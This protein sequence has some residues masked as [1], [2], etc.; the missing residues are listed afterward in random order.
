VA[1]PVLEEHP[2]RR[3][4][5]GD[6]D[7]HAVGSP[8]RHAAD[9][10]SS[11]TSSSS[12]PWLGLD[13]SDSFSPFALPL[14]WLHFHFIGRQ[15]LDERE[16]D[17]MA[18]ATYQSSDLLASPVA[19]KRNT[20]RRRVRGRWMH[21]SINRSAGGRRTKRGRRLRG[22]PGRCGPHTAFLPASFAA[23]QQHPILSFTLR[24]RRPDRVRCGRLLLLLCL[25]PHTDS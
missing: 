20:S 10:S 23:K 24:G 12:L 13:G 22:C 5:D 1:A 7:V 15:T 4:D 18:T 17:G 11:S 14:P 2:Q 8:L 19:R 25:L 9:A 21:A 16:G 6:Q 3:Q